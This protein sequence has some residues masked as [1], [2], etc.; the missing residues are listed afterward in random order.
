MPN[1][2]STAPSI[3]S[4]GLFTLMAPYD[5][6][7]T[8]GEEYT[9]QGLRTLRDIISSGIDAL[10]TVYV[11]HT[12]TDVEYNDGLLRGVLIV[13]L[14]GS[15]GQ[16]IQVPAN[17]IASLPITDGIR[18]AAKIIG[19]SL[20]PLPLDRDLS[21]LSTTLAN[22]VKDQLGVIPEVRVVQTSK[23]VVVPVPNHR[24]IDRARLNNAVAAPSDKL[25]LVQHQTTLDQALAKIQVLEAYIMANRTK[26]GI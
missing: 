15:S 20:G 13:S 2:N 18:Y 19:L 1:I 6:L 23:V 24:A 16:L 10:N 5:S 22:V 17:Y 12:L 3:G 26:L 7:T 8:P 25:K 9:C 4:R 11:A 21:L 14:Q